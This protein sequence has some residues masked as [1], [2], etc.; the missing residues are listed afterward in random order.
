MAHLL[1]FGDLTLFCRRKVVSS[2]AILFSFFRK[3]KCQMNALSSD[4]HSIRTLGRSASER[5]RVGSSG[6]DGP[7]PVIPGGMDT[8]SCCPVSPQTIEPRSSGRPRG[9]LG[10]RHL[11]DRA[12][13]LHARTPHR[14]TKQNIEHGPRRIR[15]RIPRDLRSTTFI[16]AAPTSHEQ[17][18]DHRRDSRSTRAQAKGLRRQ[19]ATSDVCRECI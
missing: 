17:L 19:R 10:S 11:F 4:A 16:P 7:C 15:H 2:P 9:A 18:S 1:R 12:V 14:L 6:R 3:D 13:R 5:V 8:L